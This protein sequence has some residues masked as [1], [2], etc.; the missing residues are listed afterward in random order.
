MEKF[1]SNK[2]DLVEFNEFVALC[3]YFILKPFILD[4]DIHHVEKMV[5]AYLEYDER[6]EVANAQIWQKRA[7]SID[8]FCRWT[9]PVGY[10][11]F[12]FRLYGS[13][14]SD[15]EQSWVT[16]WFELHLYVL[17]FSPFTIGCV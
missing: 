2:G 8:L 12:L 7:M 5:E 1:D 9:I 6:M 13:S 15:F 16:P 11:I 3:E 4:D 14:E 10:A 17:G